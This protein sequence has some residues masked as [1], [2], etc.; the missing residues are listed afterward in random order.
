MPEAF[1]GGTPLVTKV[2]VI[3]FIGFTWTNSLYLSYNLHEEFA[4]SK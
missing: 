3:V 1:D 4:L 2:D